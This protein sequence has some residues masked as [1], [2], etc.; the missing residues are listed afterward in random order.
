M[1]TDKSPGL[2]NAVLNLPPNKK[3]KLLLKLVSMDFILLSQ[4]KHQLLEDD[5]DLDERIG[6]IKQEIG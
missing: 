6:Q 1:L 2:K 3:D 5:S 4:L